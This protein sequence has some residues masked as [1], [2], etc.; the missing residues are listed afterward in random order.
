MSVFTYARPSSADEAVELLNDPA[1]LSYPLAGGT[2]VMVRVRKE[3]VWFQRLVDVSRLPELKRIER[4]NGSLVLG[5]GVSYTEA[6]ES[7]LVQRHATCLAEA[8]R[9][10]G[11]PGIA[12]M[13]TLGGNVANAA[14]CADGVPPL[15]CLEAR[16]HVRNK[17]GERV[18]PVEALLTGPHRTSLQPGDL[19]THFTLPISPEGARSAFLKLGRRNAQAIARLNVAAAGRVGEDGRIDYVR[20]AIGA[21]TPTAR[22]FVEVEAMVLGEHPSEALFVAAGRKAAEVMIQIAGRRWSTEHKER[23]IQAMVARALRR[24]IG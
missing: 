2:D 14:V 17:D 9:T 19:I 22:R 7:E 16:A 3:P 15:I 13:G 20:L 5:A 11:G 24:V 10:V 8:S 12:N 21:A 6:M 1:C 23:A 18:V 4:Q